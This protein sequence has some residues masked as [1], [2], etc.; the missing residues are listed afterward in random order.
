MAKLGYSNAGEKALS[1][2]RRGTLHSCARKFE[3]ENKIGYRANIKSMTFAY[4]HYVGAAV[5]EYLTSKDESKAF[6]AGLLE[7]DL[8][9]PYA[10]GTVAEKRAKKSFWFAM[11]A[12]DRFIKQYKNEKHFRD[13]LKDFEVPTFQFQGK[14]IPAQELTFEIDCG[15][16]FT[17]EGHIDLV[18][19]NPK[20]H[21]YM[22]LELK[23]TSFVNIHEAMYGNSDQALSYAIVLDKIVEKEGA[24]SHFAV[25]YLV[26]KTSAQ[27]YQIFR[28][29]KT[30]QQRSQWINGLILDIRLLELYERAAEEGGI[31]YPPNGASCYEF[32]KPCSLFGTCQ[33]DNSNFERLLKSD[34]E[35]SSSYAEQD[36]VMFSF[37]IE[38]IIK[39]QEF[40]VSQKMPDM[41]LEMIEVSDGLED[42]GDL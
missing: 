10:E 42:I 19:Y 8:D 2:S 28:F 36:P 21:T 34:K 23:T 31:H 18:L 26:Y 7:F 30:I 40:L 38:E 20:T 35:D 22:I 13:Q 3:I 29:G 14:D 15:D 41:E 37:T 1:Y 33:L 4:G 17:Y 24:N 39:R 11:E 6:L 27:E 16:G 9:S 5:Q 32:F 12:V 25:M